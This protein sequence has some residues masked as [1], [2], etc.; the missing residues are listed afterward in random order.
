MATS[1]V[2]MKTEISGWEW[3]CLTGN[4]Q[5]WLGHGGSWICLELKTEINWVGVDYVF[6]IDVAIF[7]W[8][9]SS[10]LH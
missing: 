1:S 4:G 3:V 6:L 5:G 9:T 2:A 7:N 10:T 8:C